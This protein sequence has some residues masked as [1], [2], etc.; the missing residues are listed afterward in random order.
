MQTRAQS[1]TES[2]AN[3]TIGYFV[4]LVA[5]MI[6]F[7]LYEIEVSVS[8]NIQIGLIFTAVS[9]A[10]SY[11]LRRFFNHYHHRSAR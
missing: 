1:L 11:L 5:Q 8:Q 9:I 7:P 4:A 3:V 6:V 10:R 2:F